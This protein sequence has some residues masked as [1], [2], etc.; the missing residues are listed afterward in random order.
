MQGERIRRRHAAEGQHLVILFSALTLLAGCPPTHDRV[1]FNNPNGAGDIGIL[2]DAQVDGATANDRAYTAPAD[3]HVDPGDVRVA[4]R[5]EVIAY[6]Q[7]RPVALV[8]NAAWTDGYDDVSVNFAPEMG[9]SFFVW[10]LKEPFAARQAQAVAACIKLD[11]IWR[12][13]RM[14]TQI[15]TFQ[16]NDRTTDTA[17][18]PFLDF[19]CAEAADIRSQIGFASG[20]VNIYYVD[21]VDFG[22]GFSTG[23]G[24]WCGN[25]TVAMGSGASDHL[26]AHEIGHAFSL[27]HVNALT[28]NFDTTNVMHNASNNRQYL[29]EG[30]TLRSHL[31]P[32]SVINTTYNLRPG[33]PTRNCGS[34]SETTTADCPAIQKRIWTDGS[35]PAN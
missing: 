19:T 15:T 11:Q 32:G 31:T 12:D 8:E 34:L 26:A 18:T 13:E 14:G 21:R 9:A 22:N 23:N 5:N 30:Q 6:Q 35:F 10:L 27:G 33:L 24:V 2:L 3:G 17:R 1:L 28:T 25:N 20:G 4:T 16:V 29:T 7:E